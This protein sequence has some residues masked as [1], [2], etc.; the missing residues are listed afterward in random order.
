MTQTDTGTGASPAH[1]PITAVVLAGGQGRRMGGQDKGWVTFRQRPMIEQVLERIRPQVSD[2]LIN[3]NRS[4]EQYQAL[5]YPVVADREAGY[6]GPLMGMLTG[7]S[8]AK[9]DWVLFVPCDTPLL[10]QDLAQKLADGAGQAGTRIAVAHDGER[11][12]PVVALLH[13]SLLPGLEQW[14][15]D[16]KRKI[17]LWYQQEGMTEVLFPAD[18]EHFTNLNTDEECRQLEQRLSGI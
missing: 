18:G 5:G 2:L 16:G 14:L 11:L 3:A 13:R 12:Q 10:P 17:D 15:A 6:H 8:A 7:L 9:T 1:N 4:L